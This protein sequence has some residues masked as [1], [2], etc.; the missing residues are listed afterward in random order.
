[1]HC[2]FITVLLDPEL[3]M[4]GRQVNISCVPVDKRLCKIQLTVS[5]SLNS[6]K[7]GSIS[8]LHGQCLGTAGKKKKKKQVYKISFYSTHAKKMI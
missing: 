3:G 7:Y 6:P 4:S 5:V 2:D 8:F 1:M